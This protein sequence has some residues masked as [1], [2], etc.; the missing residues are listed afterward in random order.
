[1][2]VS[3]SW[4]YDSNWLLSREGQDLY[5]KSLVNNSR[6]TDVQ[7]HEP[8]TLPQPGRKYFRT[9]VEEV[10]PIIEET[11]KLTMALTGV[12]D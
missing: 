9:D 5:T 11:R 10:F 4:G 1:M 6:R 12:R 2:N 3:R 8:E 7:P